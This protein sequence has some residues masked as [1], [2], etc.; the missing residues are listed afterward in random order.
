MN[1]KIN[2]KKHK[3]KPASELTL[4]EYSAFFE[5]LQEDTGNLEKLI[6]YLSITT[7]L[8]YKDVA[9]ISIDEYSITCLLA[10]IG[11]IQQP[12]DIEETDQFYYKRAG[13]TLYKKSANW[14]TL[15]IRKLLEEKREENQINLNAYL[16]A[17]MLSD[18]YDIKQI[19]SIF[20]DL[21]DYNALEVLGF[22]VFFFKSLLNSQRSG[23]NFFK[24]LMR[25]VFIN[26]MM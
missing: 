19:E 9:D 22:S 8:K 7:G 3:I 5:K 13:R 25:K 10:Y 1:I 6:L 23:N 14:R 17:G 18:D 26:T 15:G 20:K 24:R 4:G 11:T 12:K 21:Q 2:K 16:L